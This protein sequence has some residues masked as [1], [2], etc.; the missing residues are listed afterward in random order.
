[1]WLKVQVLHG[2]PRARERSAR[3]PRTLVRQAEPLRIPNRDVERLAEGSAAVEDARA[4]ASKSRAA[5]AACATLREPGGCCASARRSPA[6][7]IGPGRA[8]GWR[9]ATDTTFDRRPTMKTI[10]FPALF[11]TTTLALA[12]CG[13]PTGG[14]D[15]EPVTEAVEAL[16]ESACP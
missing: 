13:G 14:V 1:H 16:D 9:A 6:K 7:C 3:S 5:Q 10:L 11:A 12:G 8:Q 15:S 4:L 2:P